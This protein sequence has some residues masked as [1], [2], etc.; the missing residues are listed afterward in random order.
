MNM[1]VNLTKLVSQYDSFAWVPTIKG[2]LSLGLFGQANNIL[3]DV[4]KYAI[5]FKHYTSLQ[6]EHYIVASSLVTVNDTKGGKDY[7]RSFRYI[8]RG[9]INVPDYLE[10][11][12]SENASALD[13]SEKQKFAHEGVLLGRLS[14]VA[15]DS[16]TLTDREVTLLKELQVL[17]DQNVQLHRAM[18]VEAASMDTLKGQRASMISKWKEIVGII[19]GIEGDEEHKRPTF[20]FN[21]VLTRD[22]IL[23]IKDTTTPEWKLSYA[24]S[25]T[26][27]DYTQNV[28]LH[29][30]FK[31][32]MN[33][34][35]YLFHTNYHHNHEHD[36]YLPAS[37]IHSVDVN[38]AGFQ[39]IF[40]HQLDAFL[41]PVIRMK[42]SGF[43]DF[44]INSSGIILYARA[45]TQVCL[46]NGLID[47]VKAKQTLSFMDI[48]QRELEIMTQD[49]RTVLNAVLTQSN[50]IFVVSGILAFMV[51]FIKIF[52]TFFEIT[53]Q[54][55]SS[56]VVSLLNGSLVQCQKEILLRHVFGLVFIAFIGFCLYIIP[57][58][59]IKSKRFIRKDYT[60][61]WLLQNS[62]LKKATFSCKYQLYLIGQ[63]FCLKY[64]AEVKQWIKI[65]LY[66][67][68]TSVVF[69]TIYWIVRA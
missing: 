32:A 57:Q 2:S 1:A 49:Q 9:T 11:F 43:K 19:D 51:A 56:T 22:G 63:E 33:Y 52:T 17:T 25:G 54:G 39:R 4:D 7:C 45:F 21:I 40:R 37:N 67:L 16:Y 28:P 42:R 8:F 20:C 23:L 69:F 59:S 31:M 38:N 10:T 68:A 34:V 14:I 61:H 64:K 15:A 27:D 13:D 48:Q 66:C 58:S 47:D 18:D 35:K 30:V 41:G 29:R 50:P 55:F 24:A 5:A 26:A 12:K 62:N 6:S 53:R 65:V 44:P 60:P 46:N 36:T 3:G